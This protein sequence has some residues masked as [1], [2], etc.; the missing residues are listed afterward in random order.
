MVHRATQ[1]L[2]FL[3]HSYTLNNEAFP[4]VQFCLNLCTVDSS[5]GPL[6]CPGAGDAAY[7]PTTFA[8]GIQ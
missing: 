7:K 5:Q 2:A 1:A 4:A 6:S 3:M 8:H